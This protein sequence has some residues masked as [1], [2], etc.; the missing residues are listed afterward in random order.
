MLEL[1]R[2]GRCSGERGSPHVPEAPMPSWAG[3]SREFEPFLVWSSLSRDRT[4]GSTARGGERWS[5][6]EWR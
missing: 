5:G 6:C 4:I 2:V 3:R 1:V